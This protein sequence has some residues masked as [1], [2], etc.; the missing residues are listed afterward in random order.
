MRGNDFDIV[1][2]HALLYNT[3]GEPNYDILKYSTAVK[4][5]WVAKLAPIKLAE[6]FRSIARDEV[7]SVAL[8]D[9]GVMGNIVDMVMLQEEK[10]MPMIA[11]KYRLLI[12]I[13]VQSAS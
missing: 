13:I 11:K 3:Y 1:N 2:G 4:V 5:S 9:Y 10:Q 8:K 12:Q 7:Y 6:R